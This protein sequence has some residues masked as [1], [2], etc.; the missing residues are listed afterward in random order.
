M[1]DSYTKLYAGKAAAGFMSAS[2]LSG[3]TLAK[4]Y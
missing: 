2:L 3:E 1:A 4:G